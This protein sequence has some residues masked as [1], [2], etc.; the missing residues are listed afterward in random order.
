MTISSG[1]YPIP[2]SYGGREHIT[3]LSALALIIYG[4]GRVTG[5]ELAKKL[6]VNIRTVYRDIVRLQKL[7]FP[8]VSASGPSGGFTFVHDSTAETS[9]STKQDLL[10][11]FTRAGL[12]TSDTATLETI[13]GLASD[14][15]NNQ[16][17]QNLQKASTRILFDPEEWYTRDR[18]SPDFAL[19]RNA[20]IHDHRLRISFTER[21]GPEIIKDTFEPYGLVWKGGFWYVY[22][23]SH[24]EQRYRRIRMQRLI[25]VIDT[26]EVF[27]RP[28]KF[29]LSKHWRDEL[30]DFGKGKTHVVLR[31][32]QPAILEFENFN[33]KRDNK[34]TKAKDH[35][36]VEMEVDRLEW[37][38]PLVLSYAGEVRVLTPV[39]LRNKII[40]A[41]KAVLHVHSGSDQDLSTGNRQPDDTRSRA[42]THRRGNQK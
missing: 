38:I 39:E 40:T 32:D 34:I 20:V 17:L 30:E 11:L 23:K 28:E 15:L 41:S 9:V 5:E 26:G 22:G 1:P 35:W 31:I 27:I 24:Q 21:T 36:T 6:A 25:H 4:R 3:R 10:D 2:K 12:L 37:L 13:I 16:D 18:P 29:D 33:W 42:A 19:I 7:G 8:I 14:S